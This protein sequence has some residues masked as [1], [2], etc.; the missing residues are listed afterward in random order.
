MNC[1]VCGVPLPPKRGGFT[2]KYC[3]ECGVIKK[4]EYNERVNAEKCQGLRNHH[5]G[6]PNYLINHLKETGYSGGG[7][8]EA[9]KL[10]EADYGG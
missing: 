3:F 6:Y 9:T 4:M 1:Q 10:T 2:Q 8:V 7:W 5:D